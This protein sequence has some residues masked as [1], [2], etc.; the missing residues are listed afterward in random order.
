[1]RPLLATID[2]AAIQH[3]YALAQRC[4]INREIWKRTLRAF[5]SHADWSLAR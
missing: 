4:A 3:N 1:M 5:A 2:L